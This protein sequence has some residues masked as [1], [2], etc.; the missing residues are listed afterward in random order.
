LDSSF[1]VDHLDPTQDHHEAA[2]AWIVDHATEPLYAPAPVLYELAGGDGRARGPAA[3][4]EV[5]DRLDY[6]ESLPV[7]ADATREA[8]RIDAKMHAEGRTLGAVD[9]IIAGVVRSQG[10]TLVTRDGDF[11]AVEGLPVEDYRV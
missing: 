1:L 6:A 10:G 2:A 7:T 11:E 4:G 5:F 8:A 9:A 3:V